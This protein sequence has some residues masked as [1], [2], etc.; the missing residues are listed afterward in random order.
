MYERWTLQIKY[1]H[2]T[3][4]YCWEEGKFQLNMQ[5][6]RLSDVERL[7]HWLCTHIWYQINLFLPPLAVFAYA[8]ATVGRI[9]DEKENSDVCYTAEPLIFPS[10]SSEKR[11]IFFLPK[12]SFGKFG[13]DRFCFLQQSEV[14]KGKKSFLFSSWHPRFLHSF[15]LWFRRLRGHQLFKRGRWSYSCRSGRGKSQAKS[16]INPVNALKNT[17]TRVEW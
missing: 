3:F 5:T 1:T 7:Q 9:F 17:I 12:K 2:Y 14:G 15:F 8:M 4:Q 13:S 6:F 11:S 16:I 10:S